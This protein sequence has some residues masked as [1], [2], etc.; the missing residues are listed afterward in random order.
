MRTTYCCDNEKFQDY[1]VSQAGNGLSGF[2]GSRYQRGH[3]LGSFLKGLI[4]TSA[5]L[6]KKGAVSIGK[7]ALKTG[8]SM[9]QNYLNDNQKTNKRQRNYYHPR[10]SSRGTGRKRR[11]MQTDALS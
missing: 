8:L 6:L 11:R 3:G 4:K 10:T 7:Q 1:Y 2:A 5:P 9:A